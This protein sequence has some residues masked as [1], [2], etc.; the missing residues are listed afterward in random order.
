MN[1][2]RHLGASSGALCVPLDLDSLGSP[3]S[4]DPTRSDSTEVAVQ[5]AKAQ[6]FSGLAVTMPC[7]EHIARL[8]DELDPSA[9]AIG[10]VN[11]VQFRYDTSDPD[12]RP[13]LVGKNIDGW[14]AVLAL[15]EAVGDNFGEE[16]LMLGA[17]GVAL[18][19]GD[20]FAR[21]GMRIWIY[22]IDPGKAEVTA[23]C[24]RAAGHT[25]ASS[26]PS[27]DDVLSRCQGVANCTTVGMHGG[28]PGSPIAEESLDR[29]PGVSWVFDAV[30][31]PAW[32]PLLRSAQRLGRTPV[33]GMRMNDFIQREMFVLLTGTDPSIIAPDVFPS[34]MPLENPS[35]DDNE[36]Q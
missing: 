33:P 29:N 7:K 15:R 3:V 24:L 32:T 13:W 35:D 25:S 5:A 26:C 11:C 2:W 10:A 1:A 27:P 18:S 23:E 31:Y 22:D 14:G 8:C 6:R 17:G 20:S 9:R 30:C 12:A 34:G 21:L 36:I 16:V 4:E 28:P 19:V